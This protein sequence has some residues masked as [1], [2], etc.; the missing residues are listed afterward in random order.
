[1]NILSP[2]NKKIIKIWGKT[3]ER[4]YVTFLHFVKF[5]KNALLLKSYYKQNRFL[6]YGDALDSHKHLDPN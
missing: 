3:L 4:Y 5:L 1:M 2:N 6:T